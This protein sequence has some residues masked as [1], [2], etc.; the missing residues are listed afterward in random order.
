MIGGMDK[1]RGHKF[2]IATGVCPRCDM[3]RKQFDDSGQPACTGKRTKARG[4]PIKIPGKAAA[5]RA[6]IESRGRSPDSI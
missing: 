6:L 1:H 5:R 4:K 2:G 3:S